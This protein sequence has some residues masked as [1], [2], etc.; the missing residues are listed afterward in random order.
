MKIN[1]TIWVLGTLLVILGLLAA[2]MYTGQISAQSSQPG[3]VV[4][5][6]GPAISDGA[7]QPTSSHRLIIQLASPPLSQYAPSS[8]AQKLPNGKI[9]LK[10]RMR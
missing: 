3:M 9:N 6:S 1:K 4:T 8:G 7:A 5:D 2:P 10:W